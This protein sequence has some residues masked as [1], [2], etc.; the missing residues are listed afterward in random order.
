[1]PIIKFMEISI[2]FYSHESKGRCTSCRLVSLSS[3]L[4]NAHLWL[5]LALILHK[6]RLHLLH[7]DLL[8]LLLVQVSHRLEAAAT[9][10]RGHGAKG[11]GHG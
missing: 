9:G 10:R 7:P 8:L 11:T 5:L 4:A 3:W 2:L 6:L 1:M